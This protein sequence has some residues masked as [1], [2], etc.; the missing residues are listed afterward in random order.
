MVIGMKSRWWSLYLF[1]Y[2]TDN[3]VAKWLTGVGGIWLA[4]LTLVSVPLLFAGGTSAQC[5]DGPFAPPCT[6]I[7]FKGIVGLIVGELMT[8]PA[9]IFLLLGI[10]GI[11]IR[12]R[13]NW[14]GASAD[15]AVP[16][17]R[18][19][20]LWTPLKALYG[21]DCRLA[22]WFMI[23]SLPWLMGVLDELIQAHAHN[24]PPY[25]QMWI[26]PEPQIESLVDDVVMPVISNNWWNP[27]AWLMLAGLFGAV[28]WMI[29]YL[30]QRRRSN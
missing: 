9:F 15:P 26:G 13:S 25:T 20:R 24:R 5:P 6:G 14:N 10:A 19:I 23:L 3:R 22:I 29:S 21:P 28:T 4:S 12:R 2:G 18:E 7:I 30:W 8:H 27:G 1:V 11:V 16:V 17:S